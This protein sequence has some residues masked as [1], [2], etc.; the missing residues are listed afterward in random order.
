MIKVYIDIEVR[1]PRFITPDEATLPISCVSVLSTSNPNVVRSYI[2]AKSM[3]VRRF[4]IKILGKEF[5]VLVF[6][7]QTEISLLS[8]VAKEISS[9]DC[10]LGWNVKGYDLPYIY[11]RMKKVKLN[12]SILSPLGRVYV[13]QNNSG[14]EIVVEGVNVL[15]L[16]SIYS[17]VNARTLFTS[18]EK[19]SEETLGVG[20]LGRSKDVVSMSDRE[21]II[22]NAGDVILTYLLDQKLLLSDFSIELSRESFRPIAESYAKSQIVDTSLLAFSRR[23]GV[24]LPTRQAYTRTR[25][26][27]A[28]V[29]DPVVG[30]HEDVLVADFKRM[31]PSIIINFN[32]SPETVVSP[33]EPVDKVVFDLGGEKI[34]I[35][36][37]VK[38]LVPAFLEEMFKLRERYEKILAELDP[39][40][41]LYAVYKQKRQIV[42][43]TI[44]SVYG[45]FA[46][47]GN[48]NKDVKGSRIFNFSLAKLTTYLER[49][50]ISR[51]VRIANSLGFKVMYG[52]TDSIFIKCYG[53]REYDSIAELITDLL[54]EEIE[55]MYG[56]KTNLILE[57]KEHFIRVLLY[58]KKRY[59]GLVDWQDGEEVNPPILEIK[60]FE[61]VRTD[62]PRLT[63]DM[64]RQLFEL[65][66]RYGYDEVR[67]AEFI[68][69]LHKKF[70]KGRIGD[71]AVPCV[72]HKLNYKV[73]NVQAK[74]IE[75]ARKLGIDVYVG[76]RLFWVYTKGGG[77]LAVDEENLDLLEKYRDQVDIKKMFMRNVMQKVNQIL[78]IFKLYKQAKLL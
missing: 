43:D 52:D 27:G 1:A 7:V 31:Y 59:A 66:L 20:K 49:Q 11:N 41:P 58:K 5:T 13:R 76:K 38:G 68:N 55:E 24:V 6:P 77:V 60:G 69:N 45:Q 62:T 47:A 17:Q 42:K 15:D 54:N 30:L 4:R 78:S 22:Y 28:I 50:I 37:D 12:P 23:V 75:S 36:Q 16:Q 8:A 14:S 33:D 9:G 3:R 18:L 65:I 73:R 44:N 56:K 40:D 51:T 53:S 61:L 35:R 10:L 63:R 70:I 26:E 67:I 71:I 25:Y 29:I 39:H 46:Y 19:A 34:A 74:A 72:V 21:L 48:I 2:L 64:Q 32:L 57:P